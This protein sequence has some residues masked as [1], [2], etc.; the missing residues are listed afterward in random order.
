MAQLGHDQAIDPAL[1]ATRSELTALLNGRPAG[2]LDEG[3]R[4]HLVGD[5]VRSLAAG[6]AALAFDGKGGLLLEE[7][8]HRPI[9]APPEAG[10]DAADEPA[11]DAV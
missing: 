2:R 7:R 5:R 11:P 8:S 9:A 1:L 10:G 6:D 4:K 3:W